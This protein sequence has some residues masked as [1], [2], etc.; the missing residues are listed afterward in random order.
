MNLPATDVS[1]LVL[2]GSPSLQG[3]VRM[4]GPEGES[5]LFNSTADE[6]GVFPNKSFLFIDSASTG[7]SVLKH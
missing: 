5:F 6:K 7:Y 1:W 2:Q 3:P 4:V